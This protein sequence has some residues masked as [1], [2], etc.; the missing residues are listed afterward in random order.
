MMPRLRHDRRAH[1]PTYDPPMPDHT[2]ARSR[3]AGHTALVDRHDVRD[4]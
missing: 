1:R 3:G 2:R 4:A